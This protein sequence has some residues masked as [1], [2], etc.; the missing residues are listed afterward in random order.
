MP[1]SIIL[2]SYWLIH[3]ETKCR[4]RSNLWLIV[5]CQ[6]LLKFWTLLVHV[7][8]W[9][10]FFWLKAKR[11]F[12]RGKLLIFYISRW[13]LFDYVS[14]MIWWRDELPIYSSLLT[15]HLTSD[16]FDIVSGSLK[17]TRKFFFRAFLVK[18][19]FVDILIWKK[20]WMTTTVQYFSFSHFLLTF[21]GFQFHFH[22]LLFSFS[23]QIVYN[24]H[25]AN[26]FFHSF[27][28]FLSAN[29]I[30]FSFFSHVY[31]KNS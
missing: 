23:F 20:C 15:E 5:T 11:K 12:K 19:F 25:L 28:N 24:F 6:M 17:R 27:T 3:H 26:N 8:C 31:R 2:L 29:K 7:G 10:F 21:S 16:I 13:S 22:V 1:F 9:C 30:Q 14:H 18:N 4:E